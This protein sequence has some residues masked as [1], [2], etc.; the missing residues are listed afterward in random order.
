MIDIDKNQS[1][2]KHF[3]L[4]LHIGKGA[5]TK[6]S[7]KLETIYDQ[8]VSAWTIDK[9]KLVYNIK[10]PVNTTATSPCTRIADVRTNNNFAG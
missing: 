2:Y 9:N 6:A 8:I 5:L 7:S 4:A 10:I 1:S 3:K